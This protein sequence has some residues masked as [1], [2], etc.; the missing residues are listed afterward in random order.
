MGSPFGRNQSID[1]KRSRSK[2]GHPLGETKASMQ[3]K[4]A[5]KWGRSLGRNLSLNTKPKH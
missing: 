2:M 3:G 1:A 5:V 4:A